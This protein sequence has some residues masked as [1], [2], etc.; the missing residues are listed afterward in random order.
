MVHAIGPALRTA[1]IHL[2]FVV[3]K[4]YDG[5]A[6]DGPPF[7]VCATRELAAEVRE[8]CEDHDDGGRGRG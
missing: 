8:L 7:A 3:Y 1:T 6:P 5:N 2:A 4:G